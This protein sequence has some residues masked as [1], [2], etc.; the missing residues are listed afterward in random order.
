MN[1]CI[2]PTLAFT[3][4]YESRAFWIIGIV[5]LAAT[6]VLTVYFLKHPDNEVKSAG[7]ESRYYPADNIRIKYDGESDER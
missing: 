1:I 5:L 3:M 6:L 7:G 2:M 4:R